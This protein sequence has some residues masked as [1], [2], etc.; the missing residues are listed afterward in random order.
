MLS[1][2]LASTVQLILANMQ[3]K[4]SRPQY[5]KHHLL[6][7]RLQAQAMDERTLHLHDN[8]RIWYCTLAEL[9]SSAAS[10]TCIASAAEWPA[11]VGQAMPTAAQLL[12]HEQRL[13]GCLLSGK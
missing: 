9:A 12:R 13:P 8:Y 3:G 2:G 11:R 7:L 6:L 4:L 10:A 1:E 5:V